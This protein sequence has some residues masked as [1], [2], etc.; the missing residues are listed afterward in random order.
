MK[1]NDDW[2]CTIVRKIAELLLIQIEYSELFWE[3]VAGEEWAMIMQSE[4][5]VC[6]VWTKAPLFVI[7]GNYYQ[8]VSNQL[9]NYCCDKLGKIKVDS[10][11]DLYRVDPKHWID[12]FGFEFIELN[13]YHENSND[14]NCNCLNSHDAVIYN[15]SELS[16]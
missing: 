2:S 3:E 12:L 16:G 15:E 7:M 6:A 10:S 14:N 1:I 9:H 8:L 11:D 5:I 13:Y 4:S